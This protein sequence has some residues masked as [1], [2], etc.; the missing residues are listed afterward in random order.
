MDKESACSWACG[1]CRWVEE[2]I[3]KEK[4][5][6]FSSFKIKIVLVG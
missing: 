4:I 3:L 6:I 5:F 1:M 2:R